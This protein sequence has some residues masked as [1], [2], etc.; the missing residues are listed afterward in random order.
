MS[1]P[2]GSGSRS[3]LGVCSIRWL[4]GIARFLPVRYLC[5][6][7]VLFAL[8]PCVISMA[9]LA[10]NFFF[11]WFFFYERLTKTV[12]LIIPFKPSYVLADK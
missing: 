12:C 4:L 6:N 5:H 8:G 9:A 10:H 1:R 2:R 7:Q 3:L 11:F